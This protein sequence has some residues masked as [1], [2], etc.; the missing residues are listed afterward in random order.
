MSYC[1][2]SSDCGRSHVY[3]YQDYTDAYV[4]HV[5][6]KKRVGDIPDYPPLGSV[7]AE[8]FIVAY[9]HHHAVKR[10]LP[11]EPIGL[12]YDGKSFIEDTPGECADRLESLRAMGYNVP[13]YAIDALREEQQELDNMENKE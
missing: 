6:A 13:Q 8:E 4:I 5:A 3:V 2:W 1:R 7:S 11:L 10:S 12:K 9:K